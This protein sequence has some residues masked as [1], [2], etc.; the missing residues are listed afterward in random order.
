VRGKISRRASP[1]QGPE[2]RIVARFNALGGLVPERLS[3]L[4][5]GIS[6]D[7][8]LVRPMAGE[9]V[10]TCDWFLEG[11]HFLRK[12][13]PPDSV[14]WKCLARAISDVAAMGGIPR[15]FLLSLAL[16]SELTGSWLDGFLSGLA[17]ASAKFACALA[18]GDT[19]RSEKV[20]IN[21]AIA[22]N[23]GRG[24]ALLRSGA[25]PGE[26]IYVSGALGRAEAGLRELRRKASSK[27]T[28]KPGS[29]RS[30][31]ESGLDR[32]LYPEPRL[33]LGQWLSRT[34][35]ATAAMDLSDGLS[36]DLR[37]LCS[38]SR[39]GAIIDAERIPT[40]PLNHRLRLALHGGDDYELLF[41][42][43]TSRARRVPERFEN[44]TLTAIGE[45]TRAARIV[46]RE[47]AK[48]I[49][50]EPAGW[51]PFGQR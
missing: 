45:T 49:P 23:V 10:L 39:V 50:L 24:R 3:G 40:S 20:L 29:G 18:G 14:G 43:P 19:T 25:R 28:S 21:L 48:L 8:A 34:G 46:L 5:L 31:R 15:V 26:L 41:T 16:P 9:L 2:E 12:I 37:R 47:G 44:L 27:T 13:H 51:D 7:A 30:A 6:D 17:R 1:D 36:T 22:G 32:H 38:A 33:K 4:L 35:L 42:V 11:T